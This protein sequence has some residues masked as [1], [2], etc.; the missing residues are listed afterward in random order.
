MSSKKELWV[1]LSVFILPI[2]LGSAFYYWN[3]T[4]FTQ[5]TVNYGELVDPIITTKEQDI[6]FSKATPGTIQGIWTL[7]YVT[8]QCD[9]VCEKVIKNMK[10]IKILMNDDMRRLQ[11]MVL[12]MADIKIQDSDLLIAHPSQ[13]LN[14]KLMQFHK[15]TLF[16]IDPIGNIMLHYNSQNLNIKRI[17]KDLERLFK[18]SRIG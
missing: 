5:N 8:N 16:L 1:L 4:Y 12:T 13:S 9:N 2:I 14:K 11:R 10:T 15:N 6:I 17:I 3:P 7:A 18:Y